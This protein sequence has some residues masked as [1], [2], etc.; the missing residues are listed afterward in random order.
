MDIHYILYANAIL[1][2]RISIVY[3]LSEFPF[4]FHNEIQ[5]FK[6]DTK[7][8]KFLWL[9]RRFQNPKYSPSNH[10]AICVT[11][12]KLKY[13]TNDFQLPMEMIRSIN[14]SI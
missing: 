2:N 5:V 12:L 9:A 10:L 8:I 7:K 13:Y 6:F 1:Y 14:W 4:I 11:K 3:N